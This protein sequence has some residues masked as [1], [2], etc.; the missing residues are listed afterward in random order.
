MSRVLRAGRSC[1]SLRPV[2]TSGVLIDARDY[3]LAVHRAILSAERFV[4]ITGWQF[5]SR[6][7]LVR[8]QDAAAAGAPAGFLELLRHVE[9]AR[10]NLRVYLLAWDYSVVFSLEREWMQKVKF[11]WTTGDRIRFVFDSQHP[12][13]A[14]HHQKLVVVDGLIAFAGGIDLCESRWDDRDHAPENHQ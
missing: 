5:D 6:V 8:G 3:Y 4:L 14:C 13:A 7:A 2:E 1:E 9:K 11:D 10:P 12:P